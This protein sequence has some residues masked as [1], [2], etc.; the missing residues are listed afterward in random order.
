MRNTPAPTI[1]LQD[2][3]SLDPIGQEGGVLR[4]PERSGYRGT[5]IAENGRASTVVVGPKRKGRK[6]LIV[7][8]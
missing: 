2:S 6:R 7:L 4:I 1:I 5:F 8:F 3:N